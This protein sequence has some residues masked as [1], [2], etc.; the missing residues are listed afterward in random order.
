VRI[1]TCIYEDGDGQ[2]GIESKTKITHSSFGEI[3]IRK[4]RY[5]DILV[6]FFICSSFLNDFIIPRLLLL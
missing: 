5:H 6:F 4:F 2:N 1:V 3:R